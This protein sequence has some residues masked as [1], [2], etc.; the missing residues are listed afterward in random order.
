MDEQNVVYSCDGI[1]FNHAKNDLL[2]HDTAWM[3]F[4]DT[5]SERIK[6]QKAT[7]R[8]IPFIGSIQNRQISRAKKLVSG[9]LGFGGRRWGW[10]LKDTGFLFRVIKMFQSW[11]WWS[12]HNSEDQLKPNE[13]YALN[14]E[15]L[16]MN[17]MWNRS[18]TRRKNER[19]KKQIG[20]INRDESRHHWIKQ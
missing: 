19:N 3:D 7:C 12:L 8:T 18:A 6:T 10:F 11:L 1:L 20:G 4:E 9:C 15:L 2:I 16:G 13:L 14:N 17:Y 5:L